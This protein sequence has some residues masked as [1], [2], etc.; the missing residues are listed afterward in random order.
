M[1]LQE[2]SIE[3]IVF[4]QEENPMGLCYKLSYLLDLLIK[5]NDVTKLGLLPLLED[6][7]INSVKSCT[8]I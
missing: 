5:M 3:R 7:M 2:T 6:M 1:T 8:K 4:V